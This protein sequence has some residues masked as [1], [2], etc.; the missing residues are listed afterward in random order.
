MATALRDVLLSPLPLPDSA[1]E[2]ALQVWKCSD[3]G[4]TAKLAEASLGDVPFRRIGQLWS[5]LYASG[6][7]DA[8]RQ[9]RAQSTPWVRQ[10]DALA[11]LM[12]VSPNDYTAE[13]DLGPS[14]ARLVEAL[15]AV[16]THGPKHNARAMACIRAL[17]R[18]P[19]HLGDVALLELLR[20]LRF[21]PSRARRNVTQALLPRASRLE[22]ELRTIATNQHGSIRSA[23]EF[24]LSRG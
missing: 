9:F 19:E 17:E 23:A 12:E 10:L 18:L 13:I 16:L 2:L 14:D 20:R 3:A 21:L 5:F 11:A 24:V 15:V 8:C 6:D 7:R 4:W 22:S 1:A